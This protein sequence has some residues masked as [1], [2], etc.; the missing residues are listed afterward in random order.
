VTSR[1]FERGNI[2]MPRLI[3]YAFARHN[4]CKP[5]KHPDLDPL[6]FKVIWNCAP[7]GMTRVFPKLRSLC[8]NFGHARCPGSRLYCFWGGRRLYCLI[9][10]SRAL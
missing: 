3:G 7:P 10:Y 2:N 9:L 1:A 5:E 6:G 4:L 8:P